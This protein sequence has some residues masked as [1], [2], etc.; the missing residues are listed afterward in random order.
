MARTFRC[1][2][3]VCLLAPVVITG[4]ATNSPHDLSSAWLYPHATMQTAGEAP[5]D[6]RYRVSRIL[7]VDTL[8]LADDLDLLFMTDRSS[9]L[10]RWQDR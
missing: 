1:L 4:C 9:R 8:L 7:S 6:H 3:I 5:D 10:S 2:V